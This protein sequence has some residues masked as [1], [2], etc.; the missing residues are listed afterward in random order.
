MSLCLDARRLVALLLVCAAVSTAPAR[1][2]PPPP[3]DLETLRR[4]TLA[5]FEVMPLRQGVALVG[6]GLDRD[7]RVEIVDGL[8][9]DGGAPLSGAELRTRFGADA[10]IALRLSYLDNATLRTLFASAPA[11]PL[12]PAVSSPP[13]A[14][15]PPR[16]PA[17][18][19]ATASSTSPSAPAPSATTRVYRRTG[20]RIALGKAITV[21][22]DEEVIDAVI[23]IGGRIRIAGRVRDDVVAIGGSVELLPT[24]DV[25]GD[26]TALGGTVTVAP[27]ARHSGAVHHAE[28]DWPRGWGGP[29]FAG[30]WLDLG[31][32]ARWLTLAGTLTRV[33]LLA[34]AVALVMVIAGG[35]VGRIGAA[36][37]A[38]PLRAGAIGFAL[39]VV[40]VPALIVLSIVLAITIV[41]LPFIAVVIPVALAAMFMAMLLGFA[42]LAH[43]VGAWAARRLGW[44]APAAVWLA[45][46]GLALI[47]LPTVLSR[48][49]GVAPDA[50]RASAFALLAIGTIVEY[51]AWTIGLGAAA[52][53]GLGRWATTPPP[54]PQTG[55]VAPSVP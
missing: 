21:E 20:A 51:V 9:L 38:S 48:L 23:A 45:V 17:P 36:A 43:V 25:R 27:G 32:A 8:V 26:I 35:R 29:L 42:S 39:Q 5:R 18:P 14:P 2:Q 6:R 1:A 34:V 31:G 22:E 53:T 28:G 50:L 54:L 33:G 41:G 12:S 3:A 44:E 15:L 7:R 10:A 55:G 49:V 24:A 19:P 40:F 46:L 30:S 52:M 13:V 37:A 47:V 11:A 16:A 4:D